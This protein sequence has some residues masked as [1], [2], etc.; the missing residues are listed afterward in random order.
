MD[1]STRNNERRLYG[2]GDALDDDV[3]E[4]HSRAVLQVSLHTYVALESAAVST[5]LGHRAFIMIT[6]FTVINQVLGYV[7]FVRRGGDSPTGDI[8]C[9]YCQRIAWML[10]VTAHT[11]FLLG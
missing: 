9:G 4:Q 7:P 8:P 6:D 5:P 10:V 3:L 11:V 1:E 2:L